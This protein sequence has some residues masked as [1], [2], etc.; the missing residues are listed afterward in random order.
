MSLQRRCRIGQRLASVG[1]GTP[2]CLDGARA[3]PPEDCGGPRGYAHL[4][5]VLADPATPEH[6]ELVEWIGGE[7]APDAFNAAAPSAL[8][9]LYDRHPAA[10]PALSMGA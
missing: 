3:C 1:A 9:E 4:L 10:H 6:D 7:F 2:Q 5:E 8:L